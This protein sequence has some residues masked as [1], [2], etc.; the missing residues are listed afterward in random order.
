MDKQLG[1]LGVILL[2]QRAWTEEHIPLL[3]RLKQLALYPG[4]QTPVRGAL[5]RNSKWHSRE[6]A[7]QG[8]LRLLSLP[9]GTLQRGLAVKLSAENK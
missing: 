9:S 3:E 7:F 8:S 5:L 1:T 4:K 2:L 6:P